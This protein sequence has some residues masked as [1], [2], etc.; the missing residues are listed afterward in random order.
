MDK[1]YDWSDFAEKYN[2][3]PAEN[4]DDTYKSFGSYK[5][6]GKISGT[7]P[8][9]SSGWHYENIS[10]TYN[11]YIIRPYE[12]GARIEGGSGNAGYISETGEC[13]WY[14]SDNDYLWKRIYDYSYEMKISN[15]FKNILFNGCTGVD[16]FHNSVSKFSVPDNVTINGK[17]GDD[18]LLNYG[19]SNVKISGGSGDDLIS[20]EATV[21]WIS[22]NEYIR[23]YP[24]DTILDGG[25]GADTITNNGANVTINGGAGNDYIYNGGYWDSVTIDGGRRKQ[26]H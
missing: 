1:L 8:W 11:L 12:D 9:Y 22:E 25:V 15:S 7:H 4:E 2:L 14:D 17:D 20:N 21:I 5:L 13:E 26:H 24:T 19:G 10:R 3:I 23:Y 16:W 6:Y 18:S